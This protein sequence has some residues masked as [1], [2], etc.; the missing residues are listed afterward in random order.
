MKYRLSGSLREHEWFGQSHQPGLSS[1]RQ[2]ELCTMGALLSPTP[3]LPWEEAVSE[4]RSTQASF[5]LS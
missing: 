5:A 4:R 1:R 3:T 2:R